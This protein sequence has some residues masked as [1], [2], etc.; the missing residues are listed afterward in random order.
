LLSH[1]GATAVHGKIARGSD[2]HHAVRVDA[3]GQ[4]QNVTDGV[5][6]DEYFLQLFPEVAAGTQ[7]VHVAEDEEPVL[8]PGE[9]NVD[10]VL[11]REETDQTLR[12]ASHERE[13]DDVVLLAL[14]AVDAG[15]EDLGAGGEIVLDELTKK[16]V[17]KG[18]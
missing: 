5:L 10:P 14:V 7:S 1:L 3:A 18:E 8:G 2:V 6:V 4:L 9:C 15:D 16:E 13:E 17:D 12:V 11:G